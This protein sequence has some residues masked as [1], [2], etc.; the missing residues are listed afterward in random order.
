MPDKQNEKKH[1]PEIQP[2]QNQ[3]LKNEILWGIEAFFKNKVTSDRPILK[4]TSSSGKFCNIHVS[5]S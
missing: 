5:A 2:N 4:T 1:A 3:T